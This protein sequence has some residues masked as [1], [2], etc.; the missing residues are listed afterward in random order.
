MGQMR[1]I[2]GNMA[3][4]ADVADLGNMIHGADA[5]EM[6]NMADRANVADMAEDGCFIG[7]NYV[8]CGGM[9]FVK[10]GMLW[11]SG[12]DVRSRCIS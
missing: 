1:L 2:R 6:G 11:A 5:A 9:Y 3:D 4:R 10:R 8:L 7:R 12:V